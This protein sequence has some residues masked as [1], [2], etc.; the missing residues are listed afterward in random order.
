MLIVAASFAIFVYGLVAAFLGTALPDLSKRFDLTPSRNG[1]IAFAQAIGLMLASLGAG[2]LIDLQGKKIALVLGTL[3]I[4]AALLLLP[5]SRGFGGVVLLMFLMG[6]GGG[7]MVTGANALASDTGDAHRAIALNLA[8]VFFGLG[9][10]ITPF[11]TA[12]LFRGNSTKMGYTI[13]GIA[14]VSVAIQFLTPMAR[15]AGGGRITLADAGSV[16]GRAPLILI[17]LFLFLY[18]SCEVGVWNWLVRHMIAQGIPAPRAMNTL[19]LGFALGLLIGR[20]AILPV[21]IH[22]R[23][24][25]VT[26]VGSIC[27]AVTTL[28]VIQCRSAQLAGLFVFLAG[29]S[30]APMFPTALAIVPEFFPRLTS[31]AIGVAI[32]FGWAGLAVSSRI[33]GGIAGGDATRLKKALLVL[34]AFSCVMVV[35]SLLMRVVR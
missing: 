14:V 7:T 31:T 4:L 19:S 16:L 20:A 5:R 21:L 26:L 9:G 30:M 32:T 13:A 12:N 11:L 8:N 18:V 29:L 2:P 33:I 23:P 10:L 22:V 1:T 24:L 25:T 34:P 35:L 28:L 3:L 17:G 27:M 6:L 15:P